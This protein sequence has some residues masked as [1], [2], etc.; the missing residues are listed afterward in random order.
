M[1]MD[2]RFVFETPLMWID[3]AQTWHLTKELGG[4]GLVELVQEHTHTCYLG[5]RSERHE[6]GYGKVRSP[7]TLTVC[8]PVSHMTL[9]IVSLPQAVAHVPH[10]RS[11]KQAS[12]I[13]GKIDK[14]SLALPKN[15]K[16][17]VSALPCR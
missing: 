10:V 6:W 4:E 5:D 9:T 16:Q 12:N 2:S 14:F 17:V 3:K 8:R 1:G 11:A 15:T 7:A 13:S